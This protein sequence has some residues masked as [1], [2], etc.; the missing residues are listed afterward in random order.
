MCLQCVT[1][2]FGLNSWL[3]AGMCG[4]RFTHMKY[5]IHGFVAKYI[6]YI[7]IGMYMNVCVLFC[8]CSSL[9][10]MEKNWN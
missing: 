7:R 1:D 9:N 4:C 10:V 8:G 6:L 3:A 2:S 5:S